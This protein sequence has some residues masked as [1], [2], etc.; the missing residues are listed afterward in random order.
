VLVGVL[1]VVVEGYTPP[2]SVCAARWSPA[3]FPCLLLLPH[4]YAYDRYSS[5]VESSYDRYS[6]LVERFQPLLA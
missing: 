3:L 5:L 4:D 2:G 1:V 6:S